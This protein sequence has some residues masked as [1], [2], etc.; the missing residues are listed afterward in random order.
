RPNLIQGAWRGVKN[1]SDCLD[2]I[3]A[4]GGSMAQIFQG[5]LLGPLLLSWRRNK[6]M[7]THS[8]QKDLVFLKAL[9]EVG[10]VLPVIDRCYPLGEVVEAIKYL[11]EGHARGKVVI[12]VE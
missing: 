1:E 10:R 11:L 2:E 6:K 9:L 8:E 4:A 12:T 5:M 3:R 7:L